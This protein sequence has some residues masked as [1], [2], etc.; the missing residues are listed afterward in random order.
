MH[1]KFYLGQNYPNP[2]N[3]VTKIDFELSEG[4]FISLKVYDITSREV[5]VLE[6]SEL[7]KGKYSRIINAQNLS[8]GIYFY[9]IQAGGFS[10]TRPMILLK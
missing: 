1:K 10:L 4:A 3:P 9:R 2:F 8:S 6:N 5:A 7:K